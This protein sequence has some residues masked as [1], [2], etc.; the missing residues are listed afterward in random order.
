MTMRGCYLSVVASFDKK[1]K[2]YH[3]VKERKLRKICKW[4]ARYK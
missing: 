1:I 3:L 2:S 4:C